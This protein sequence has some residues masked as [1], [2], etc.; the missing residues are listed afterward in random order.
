MNNIYLRLG[1]LIIIITLLHRFA[2]TPIKYPKTETS[3]NVIDIYHGQYMEDEYR[4]LEDDNSK[5]TEAW[6][7]KQN[8]FTDRYFRKI[9]FNTIR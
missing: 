7:H 3:S 2:P 6:I 4:W 9:S 5:Q 1:G 8:S